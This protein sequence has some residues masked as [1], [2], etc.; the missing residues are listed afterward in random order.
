MKRTERHHLKEN[1]L[2]HLAVSARDAVSARKSVIVPLTIALVLLVAA[3][4]GYLAWR[5]R[6]DGRADTLL[7]EALIV[8]EARVGPPPAPGQ[9]ATGMSFAT[10]REKHQAALTK[11][12]IV[13]DQ[14]PSTEAGLFAR[15]REGTTFMALGTPASAARS[16]QQ[17]IDRGDDTLYAQMARLGLAEA[18]A[19]TG[20]YDQAISTFKDLSQQ[21]DGQVPIDGVLIRLGRTYLDAG[22]RTE[23]EQTFNRLVEEFPDSP[24]TTDARRALDQLK[25]S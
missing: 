5:A 8:E 19:Q 20:Q 24:F 13:A 3:V 21:K 11:F 23:A 2:A 16:Y 10:E 25:K 6:V 9:P 14:Y 15:Y 12:K 22:K 18:Q 7:A 1:A 17:V 4:A